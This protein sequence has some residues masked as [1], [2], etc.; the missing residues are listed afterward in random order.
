MLLHD[1]IGTHLSMTLR[2]CWL[3]SGIWSLV[4]VSSS[5]IIL[6]SRSSGS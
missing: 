2:H 5:L 3:T 1:S 4:F 6:M